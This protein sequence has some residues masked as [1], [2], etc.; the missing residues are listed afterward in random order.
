[1]I[2]IMFFCIKSSLISSHTLA[3]EAVTM[4][5]I[6]VG[7][8]LWSYWITAYFLLTV[9]IAETH[10]MCAALWLFPF[11]TEMQHEISGSGATESVHLPGWTSCKTWRRRLCTWWEDYTHVYWLTLMYWFRHQCILV[12]VAVCFSAGQKTLSR[13]RNL[14]EVWL[15]CSVQC[16]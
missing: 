8:W 14:Q 7:V 10:T 6:G 9:S 16:H 11:L 1:M 4:L 15:F 5:I 13:G 2:I 12:F 3:G